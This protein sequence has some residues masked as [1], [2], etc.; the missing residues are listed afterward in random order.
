[1]CRPRKVPSAGSQRSAASA[2]GPPGQD[3]AESDSQVHSR[4]IRYVALTA[5]VT[6]VVAAVWATAIR[7][8]TDTHFILSNHIAVAQVQD[9]EA[10]VG[11]TNLV[12]K[13]SAIQD[14]VSA[15]DS[16]SGPPVAA[17][18]VPGLLLEL[19]HENVF[20]EGPG[21]P[22]ADCLIQ[23]GAG[24]DVVRFWRAVRREPD[25]RRTPRGAPVVIAASPCDLIFE[26]HPDAPT[27]TYLCPD[28][29]DIVPRQV[30]SWTIL[31]DPGHLYA[32]INRIAFP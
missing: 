19:G 8:R 23:S 4:M 17:T 11:H 32:K 21:V 6:A 30:R 15:V 7:V 12:W 31:R 27:A 10:D 13:R 18:K 3:P 25:G 29:V 22:P 16:D 1:M 24:V 28:C 2:A 20:D 26:I 9:Q 5:F 14:L